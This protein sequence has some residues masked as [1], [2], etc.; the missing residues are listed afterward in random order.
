VTHSKK[1]IERDRVDVTPGNEKSA[2][3]DP[4]ARTFATLRRC[5]EALGRTS[6]T[7]E[8]FVEFASG[9]TPRTG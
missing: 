7:I 1:T 2:D 9:V 3:A 6:V 8:E 4:A 5:F